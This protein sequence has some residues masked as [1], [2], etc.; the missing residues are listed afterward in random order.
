MYAKLGRKGGP[1]G[2]EKTMERS[3]IDKQSFKFWI[4]KIKIVK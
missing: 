4:G 2:A 3:V 1:L